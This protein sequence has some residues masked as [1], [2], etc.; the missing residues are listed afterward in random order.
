MI[1]KA[2]HARILYTFLLNVFIFLICKFHLAKPI[3]THF[4]A[5]I[6]VKS[7]INLPCWDTKH[8]CQ[9]YEL[10]RSLLLHIHKKIE[11]DTWKSP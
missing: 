4:Q 10:F 8:T 2:K 1:D 9:D 3:V 6:G 7:L 5:E 11:N